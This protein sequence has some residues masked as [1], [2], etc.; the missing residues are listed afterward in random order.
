MG[1]YHQGCSRAGARVRAR[2][3]RM[4]VKLRG[5]AGVAISCARRRQSTPGGISLDARTAPHCAAFF[6]TP[7]V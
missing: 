7:T 4:Y 6:P 5:G 2:H 1:V 3:T